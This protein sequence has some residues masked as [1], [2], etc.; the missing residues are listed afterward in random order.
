MNDIVGLIRAA[1]VVLHETIRK[2]T[3]RWLDEPIEYGPQ[4]AV[5]RISF[6]ASEEVVRR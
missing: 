1:A 4:V 3:E 6:K 2:C 5:L